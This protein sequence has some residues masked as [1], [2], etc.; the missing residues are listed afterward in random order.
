MKVIVRLHFFI[1]PLHLAC[2]KY[3]TVPHAVWQQHWMCSIL[4]DEHTLEHTSSMAMSV[5]F[6]GCLFPELLF[7]HVYKMQSEFIDKLVN[8]TWG[9][10]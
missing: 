1:K 8:D 6:S 5:S 7:N 3:T 2:G 10:Y 4:A 9:T